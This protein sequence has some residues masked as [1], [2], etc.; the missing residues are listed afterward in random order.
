VYADWVGAIVVDNIDVVAKWTL[1]AV[2]P[3]IAN[4][5]E[6]PCN[7]K[8]SFRRVQLVLNNIKCSSI[9]LQL[10]PI[11][12][13]LNKENLSRTSIWLLARYDRLHLTKALS[14]LF[15]GMWYL[16]FS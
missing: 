2:C 8:I 14:S 9:L 7:C 4:R 6:Y 3:F 11:A 10:Q 13:G 15:P 1:G 12:H 5:P 16:P